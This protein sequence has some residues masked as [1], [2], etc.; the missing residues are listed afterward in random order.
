MLLLSHLSHVR[1]YATP[2]EVEPHDLKHGAY[3]RWWNAEAVQTM[4][5]GK[6]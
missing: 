6:S 3:Q 5:Q 1:L 2:H 4:T